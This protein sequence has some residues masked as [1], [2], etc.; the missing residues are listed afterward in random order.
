MK[1]NIE[2]LETQGYKNLKNQPKNVQDFIN[3]ISFKKYEIGWNFIRCF[4]KFENVTHGFCNCFSSLE[5]DVIVNEYDVK[6]YIEFV[7]KIKKH[8][9]VCEIVSEYIEITNKNLTEAGYNL[10]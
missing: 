4:G 7:E 10:N 6:N 5:Y 8:N 2:Y 9:L 1:T 3:D